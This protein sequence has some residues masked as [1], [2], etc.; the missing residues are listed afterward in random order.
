M[1]KMVTQKVNKHLNILQNK[2]FAFFLY[3]YNKS[4]WL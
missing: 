1:V 4:V 3:K 2:Q